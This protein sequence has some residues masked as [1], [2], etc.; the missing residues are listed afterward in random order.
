MKTVIVGVV[1]AM[2][3][4]VSGRA[5]AGWGKA[6]VP[7]SVGSYLKGEAVGVLVVGAGDRALSGEAAA[8]LANALRASAK[9]KVVMSDESLG[10]LSGLDDQAIVKKAAGLPIDRVVVVRV[11]PGGDGRAATAVVTVYRKDGAEIDV[12]FTAE[13]GKPLLGRGAE[14]ES[15]GDGVSAGAIAS[16]EKVVGTKTVERSTAEEEYQNQVISI[17]GGAFVNQFGSVVGSWRAATQGKY[18]K[19][20]EGADFYEVVGRPDLAASYR[21]K[22]TTKTLIII[23]GVLFIAGGAIGGTAMLLNREKGTSV[24][25]EGGSLVPGFVVLSVGIGLGLIATVI[26]SLINPHPVTHNESLELVDK[27]NQALRKKL[28]LPALPPKYTDSGRSRLQLT[29]SPMLLPSGG[30]LSLNGVF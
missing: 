8:A 20:L 26:G 6:F 24:Y 23:S 2:L 16:V 4:G 11:F 22:R 7:K 19:P 13:K 5:E 30:G 27:H 15:V 28:G 9:A 18:G 17:Q 25:D 29:L 12:A 3:G 21:S 10:A 14:S 1:V